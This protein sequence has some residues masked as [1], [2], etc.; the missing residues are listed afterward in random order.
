L[1]IVR[2]AGTTRDPRINAAI[3]RLGEKRVLRVA[4]RILRAEVEKKG[5]EKVETDEKDKKRKSETG[6]SAKMGKMKLS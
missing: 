5:V 2:S 4:R 1:D 3:V 6:R